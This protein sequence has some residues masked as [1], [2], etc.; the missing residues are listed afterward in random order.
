MTLHTLHRLY[1]TL[2]DFTWTLHDFTWTLHGVCKVSCKLCKVSRKVAGKLHKHSFGWLRGPGG[3]C[4]QLETRS[5]LEGGLCGRYRSRY[6]L[7]D[8]S[9]KTFV[10]FVSARLQNR[11]KGGVG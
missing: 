11:P 10:I 7:L 1:V 3:M 5:P 2:H 8:F 9:R 4:H 6:R